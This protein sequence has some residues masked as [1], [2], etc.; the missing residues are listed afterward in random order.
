MDW[1]CG[2]HL[3]EPKLLGGATRAGR[4]GDALLPPL[5]ITCSTNTSVDY[6]LGAFFKPHAALKF[7]QDRRNFTVVSSCQ[8]PSEVE[9]YQLD[10]IWNQSQ[11]GQGEDEQITGQSQSQ[12]V[13]QVKSVDT[14]FLNILA[15]SDLSL[16]Y[17]SSP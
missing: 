7:L 8:F 1:G 14:H 4:D 3:E 16:E 9:S 13:L 5:K 12:K 2:V 10:E 11:P 6:S 17:S 15:S